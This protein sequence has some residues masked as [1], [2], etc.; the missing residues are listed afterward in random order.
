MRSSSYR[1]ALPL[2]ALLVALVV[3]R[4]AAADV[5]PI[6][7]APAPPSAPGATPT[8]TASPVSSTEPI[9][10]PVA[11]PASS[12]PV[13][14][15][16]P[17]PSTETA[18]TPSPSPAPAAVAHPAAAVPPTPVSAPAE[19]PVTVPDQATLEAKL[20]VVLRSYTLLEEENDQLKAQANKYAMERDA[21]QAQFSTAKEAMPLAAQAAGLREQLRQTQDQLAAMSLE[22]NQLKTRL[23]TG[24]PAPGTG[25]LTPMNV[26]TTLAPAAVPAAPPAAP[27]VRIHVVTAGETLGKISKQYYGTTKRWPE[28]L[29]ANSDVLKSE[30]NVYVGMKLKI[31]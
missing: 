16:T 6:T 3:G 8:P 10:A 15:P 28:I 23:A 30:K 27:A 12:A 19:A 18:P 11:S 1:F 20:A 17:T 4:A 24:G 26:P 7:P 9:P 14:T 29:A 5:T 25:N 31:P 21:L 22:N 2:A 13:P